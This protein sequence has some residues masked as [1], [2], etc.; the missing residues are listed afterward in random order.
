M[1][2]DT[3]TMAKDDLKGG[4]ETAQV[5]EV[6]DNRGLALA[7]SSIWQ[8][9]RKI[10]R[11]VVAG[12]V[13]GV[14]VA[15]IIRPTYQSTT[16][17]MPPDS[18]SGGMSLLS[19][20]LGGIAGGGT[21]S[22]GGNLGGLGGLAGDLLGLKS[23]GD[24]LVEVLQSRTVQ[25]DLINRF[26]LRKVYR[27]KRYVAARKELS[28]NTEI[29]ASRKG[30]IITISVYDR[31]PK[32]AT[33]MA[34]EYVAELNR[35]MAQVSTSAA[36]REREFLEDRLK[37]VKQELD[38]A[39]KDLSQYSSK[40]ATLD[41][42]DEGK[43]IV[44][45]AATLQGQLIAA[46]SELKGLE[47][48]YTPGNVRV[49]SLQARVTE[50]ERKLDE[51]GGTKGISTQNTTVAGQNNDEFLVPSLR[52][53]PLLGVTYGDL[54][55]RVK[56]DETVYAFLTQE[57]ELARVQEAKEI[58]SVKVL[59][60]ASVPERRSSPP[61]LALTILFT[62][63]F[64]LVGI[65]WV[66]GCRKWDETDPYTPWKLTLFDIARDVRST[67]SWRKGEDVFQHLRARLHGISLLRPRGK[68]SLPEE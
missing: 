62:V 55:R 19:G 29:S 24:L 22:G 60:P 35:L 5:F 28:A 46:Q 27:V 12:F 65:V 38:S 7:I 42:Q 68:V 13:I 66:L 49:K 8:S 9:R 3:K 36:R 44:D 45:A 47:Q 52:Q 30:G 67:R 61:R 39:S 32:R 1:K 33:A 43:A 23:T 58:P 64:F 48:I 50:L 16:Q 41:I 40:N 4:L 10:W 59:D 31:D 51:I 17:L 6:A 34:E 56:I 37:V 14:L 26:D 11:F 20:L 21:E 2:I 54:Y 15:F 63:F 18:G 57:Y 25:D 53:L